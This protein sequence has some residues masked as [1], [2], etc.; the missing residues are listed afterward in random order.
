MNNWSLNV[1][2]FYGQFN[3]IM[4]VLGKGYYEM[5]AF[6]IFWRLTV[7]LHWYMLVRTVL[8]VT[9]TAFATFSL[10]A[11]ERASHHCRCF[12]TPCQCP[13]WSTKANY[14]SGKNACKWQCHFVYSTT[15]GLSSFHDTW[16]H[17]HG[18]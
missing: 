8:V 15:Y 1:R 16:Q 10:V 3:N 14:Y 13:T 18:V 5:T 2:R 6:W 17:I 12:V 11:G 4:S 9:I 7:C